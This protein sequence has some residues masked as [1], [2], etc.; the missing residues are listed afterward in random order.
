MLKAIF[1]FFLDTLY[2]LLFQFLWVEKNFFT[3][4]VFLVTPPLT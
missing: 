2:M 1:A 4:N 3:K